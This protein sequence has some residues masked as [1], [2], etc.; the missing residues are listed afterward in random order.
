[1]ENNVREFIVQSNLIESEYGEDAVQEALAAWDYVQTQDTMTPEVVKKTHAIL[2][3]NRS[4]EKK[5]KGEYRDCP[6]YI[7]GHAAMNAAKVPFAVEEWC[8]AMNSVGLRTVA[9]HVNGTDAFK[10]Q[11]SKSLHIQY[12]SIHPFADGNGRTGRIFM[13]WWRLRAGLPILVINSD[14]PDPLGEQAE[15]YSWF[16]EQHDNR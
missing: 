4:L 12:E 11:N 8:D 7:G 2:M 3:E 6:V 1:M 13:N 14:W 15:Y 10:E 16:R 9:K 5:F